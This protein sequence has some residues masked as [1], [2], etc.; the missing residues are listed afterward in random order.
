LPV[1]LKAGDVLLIALCALLICFAA[2]LYPARQAAD[3]DPVE[4]IRH[5]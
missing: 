5:G 2:T 3:V 1:N 4:A